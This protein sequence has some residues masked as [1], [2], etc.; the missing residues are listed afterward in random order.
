[1]G[2]K[3]DAGAYSIG[4]GRLDVFLEKF[5]QTM[6]ILKKGQPPNFKLP[7]SPPEK[8]TGYSP[9]DMLVMFQKARLSYQKLSRW[10][11]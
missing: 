6:A 5:L 2:P 8:I 1:L 11:S 7:P 4:W 10:T 9:G 3:W